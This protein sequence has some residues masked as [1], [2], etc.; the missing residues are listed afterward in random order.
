MRHAP[1]DDAARVRALFALER[2]EVDGMP[3][4][5]D[6]IRFQT[7]GI[8]NTRSE[9]PSIWGSGWRYLLLEASVNNHQ[10]F[11]SINTAGNRVFASFRT[12]KN[13]LCQKLVGG[14]NPS[15]KY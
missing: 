2:W 10:E 12:A 1:I 9:N 14:L 3:E 8:F 6:R 15:E 13:G 5:V 7:L 11:W 4:L